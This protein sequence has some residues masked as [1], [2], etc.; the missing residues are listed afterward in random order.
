MAGLRAGLR[1]AIIG[2]GAAGADIG[3]SERGRRRRR[4]GADH[5][6]AGAGRAM[7]AIR[8]IDRIARSIHHD[9]LRALGAADHLHRRG[10]AG[11]RCQCHRDDRQ[12]HDDR[13]CGGSAAHAG[14]LPPPDK[15]ALDDCQCRP[16]I[17]PRDLRPEVARAELCRCWPGCGAGLG[18]AVA[19][20]C[21][22]ARPLPC[23][24]IA[25]AAA[26]AA[27]RRSAH[28][29]ARPPPLLLGTAAVSPLPPVSPFASV[30][31]HLPGSTH[32][33]GACPRP[34]ACPRLGPHHGMTRTTG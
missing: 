19:F 9:R 1:D 7:A 21:R 12:Q 20:A 3:N 5:G 32:A 28:R 10:A 30:F 27:W 2:C 17:S 24:P 33:P 26:A 16:L 31:A 22:R 13:K 34:R 18:L 14:A 11:Q 25:V 23:S 29:R 8:R 6:A 15:A 4:R